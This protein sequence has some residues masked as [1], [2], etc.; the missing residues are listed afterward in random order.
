MSEMKWIPCSE[1]LP[2]KK[3]EYLCSYKNEWRPSGFCVCIL[4]YDNVIAPGADKQYVLSNGYAFGSE[5]PDGID[6]LTD[7]DAWMPVPEPYKEG[8]DE[9][10]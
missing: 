9:D 6:T 2:E 10:S 5:W 8:Q 4:D 3:G 7:V 1:R